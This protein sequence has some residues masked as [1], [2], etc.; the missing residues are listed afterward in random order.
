MFK[1][2]F[3]FLKLPSLSS[4]L[5]EAKDKRG[6]GRLNFFLWKLIPFNAPHRFKVIKVNP[7]GIIIS[8]PFIR[9]NR[10]HIRGLHACA[11]GALCEYT[12]GLQLI[13][14][15]GEGK[16]RIILK[17]LKVDY[18]Y[19]GKTEVKAQFELNSEWFQ[20]HIEKPLETEESIIQVF[21]VKVLDQENKLICTG[22]PEWQIKPWN[23]VKT[24]I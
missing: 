11:L 19:Q 24:K 2:F 7:Y 21:E 18:H 23:R 20:E 14:L 9:K 13:R 22:Y 6:L 3:P 10:N 4:L 15:A 1:I 16:Y 12:C 17:S 5:E 8:L